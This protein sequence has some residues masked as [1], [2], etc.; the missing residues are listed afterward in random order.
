MCP[1]NRSEPRG[2]RIADS[3]NASA[4]RIVTAGSVSQV[5]AED[6]IQSSEKHP[7]QKRRRVIQDSI[8]EDSGGKSADECWRSGFR[9]KQ[10]AAFS[11]S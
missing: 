9:L 1:K 4:S 5:G 8:V 6:S 2:K 11:N 7:D 3:P 10:F